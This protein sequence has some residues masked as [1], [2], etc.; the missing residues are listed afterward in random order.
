MID[1]QQLQILAQL[2]ENMGVIA[3]RLERSY[4][5]NDSENF[6]LNKKELLDTQNKFSKMIR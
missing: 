3:N 1:L 4:N 5:D 2:V 6:N